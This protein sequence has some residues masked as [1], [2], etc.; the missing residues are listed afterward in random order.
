[1]VD[2][3]DQRI[4]FL[5]KEKCKEKHMKKVDTLVKVQ[6]IDGLLNLTDQSQFNNQMAYERLKLYNKPMKRHKYLKTMR[7]LI[8]IYIH[9]KNGIEIHSL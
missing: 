8:V 5:E 4:E 9:E 1:M 7:S 2:L 6:S 3:L